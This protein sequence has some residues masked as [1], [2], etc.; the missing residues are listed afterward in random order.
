MKLIEGKSWLDV[1]RNDRTKLNKNELVDLDKFLDYDEIKEG[2]IP[3]KFIKRFTETSFRNSIHLTAF[4]QC[5][6]KWQMVN[7]L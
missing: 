7:P 1:M 6:M 3:F 5:G 2:E 4:D